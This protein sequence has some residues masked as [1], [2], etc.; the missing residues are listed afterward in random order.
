VFCKGV[1]CAC[2]VYV[3]MLLRSLKERFR[4][5]LGMRKQVMEVHSSWNVSRFAR[6]HLL[7]MSK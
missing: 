2:G 6:V 5:C 3:I 1:A 7:T 4:E